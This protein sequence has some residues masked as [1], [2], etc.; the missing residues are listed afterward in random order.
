MKFT[1]KIDDML[2]TLELLKPI[3]PTRTTLPIL[4]ML[5][6]EIDDTGILNIMGSDSDN[7]M[8]TNL[9][10][11][12]HEA[13]SIL[14]SYNKLRSL[15]LALNSDIDE[16]LVFDVDIDNNIKISVKNGEYKMKGIN[17][18]EYL[19]IYEFHSE[20]SINVSGDVLKMIKK[21][22]F[23]CSK[24]EYRP[25]MLGVYFAV[26]E[27]KLSIVATDSYMM[28]IYEKPIECEDIEFIVPVS[29]VSILEKVKDKCQ[30]YFQYNKKKDFFAKMRFECNEFTLTTRVIEQ[31]FPAYKKVIPSSFNSCVIIDVKELRSCINRV[32]LFSD[33]TTSKVKVIGDD[34]ILTISAQG[35]TE[36]ALEKYYLSTPFNAEFVL[37]YK[38]WNNGLAFIGQECEIK[39][40]EKNKPIIFENAEE[41]L[42]YLLM[43]L[44][45]D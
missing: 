45:I 6:M 35:D 20:R 32:S 10:V 14:V 9:F 43:P 29:I 37:N 2:G 11:E 25:A 21:V 24:D 30:I 41:N 17:S 33:K 19:D 44:R 12:S 40:F 18:D 4:E 5:Y 7:F 26:S 42:T 28:A 8:K 3:I 36:S 23:A 13:G 34:N 31:S 15:L 1:V 27:N 22:S 16:Y 39:F 38:L